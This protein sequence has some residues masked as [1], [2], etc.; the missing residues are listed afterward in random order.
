MNSLLP[1]FRKQ[2]LGSAYRCS[3]QGSSYIPK[4]CIK[5]SHGPH[6]GSKLYYLQFP[7]S[8][9]TTSKHV[10]GRCLWVKDAEVIQQLE[11]RGDFWSHL[12]LP[13]QSL[14]HPRQSLHN[15]LPTPWNIQNSALVLRQAKCSQHLGR[16]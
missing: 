2:S 5:N 4:K 1:E 12:S 16:N 11:L 7:A 8:K 14:H 10:W 6:G 3:D 13:H 9:M 15:Q